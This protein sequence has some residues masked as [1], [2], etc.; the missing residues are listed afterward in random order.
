MNADHP[1]G[2]QPDEPIYEREFD[3]DWYS[4]LSPLGQRTVDRWLGHLVYD[5]VAVIALT[6]G[7]GTTGT[8]T[9]VDVADDGE[10]FLTL[11]YDVHWDDPF[12]VDAE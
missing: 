12:P 10:V 1:S 11:V 3:L 9:V 2:G 8:L 7:S 6:D 5:E 4:Q